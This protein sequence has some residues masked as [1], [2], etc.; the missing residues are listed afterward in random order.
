MKWWHWLVLEL[1]IIFGVM[2][3][4]YFFPSEIEEDFAKGLFGFVLFYAI[5]N[6][7]DINR[8]K[9]MDY[10]EGM[11]CGECLK[12][13]FC[14]VAN[15]NANHKACMKIT[16]EENYTIEQNAGENRI[17]GVVVGISGSVAKQYRP[18][19]DCEELIRCYEKKYA[20]RRNACLTR[21]IIWIRDKTE[22]A[23]GDIELIT[24]FTKHGNVLINGTSYPLQYLFQ[25]YEFLDG[26]PVGK[27]EE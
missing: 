16:T 21:P 24:G 11:T 6:C 14:P 25:M 1:L 19:K 3:W 15:H 20:I 7:R 8:R 17:E 18:F 2:A 4:I 9:T 23:K 12:Y 26:S 5:D 10:K 22:D 27:L 13:A